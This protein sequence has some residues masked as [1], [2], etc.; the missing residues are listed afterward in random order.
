ML[1]EKTKAINALMTM[2]DILLA[3]ISFNIALYLEFGRFS[4]LHHKDSVILQLL[5]VIFWALLSNGMGTNIMY[6]SRPYL[7]VLFNCLG[8]TFAG[9]LLLILSAWAFNLFYLGIHLFFIFGFIHLFS[10]LAPKH[11]PIK[12]L[13]RLAKKG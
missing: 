11:L 2:V 1:K 6:R 10:P 9:T 5:I 8:L 3:I 13:N 7:I 12:Y 4:V